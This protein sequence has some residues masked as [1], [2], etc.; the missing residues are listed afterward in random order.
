MEYKSDFIERE[1]QKIIF[2]LRRLLAKISQDVNLSSV[3]Q[4]FDEEF[5]EKLNFGFDEIFEFN[6]DD[7]KKK[8]N[9]IDVLILENLLKVFYN[10]AK[11]EVLSLKFN[12]LK[13]V[14]LII[15]DEIE[16]KSSVYSLERSRIKNYFKSV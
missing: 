16:N 13:R 4:S 6:E 14:S 1:V 8:I 5:K 2:F 9:R 12:D 3:I 11:K 10:I 7:L 15:L